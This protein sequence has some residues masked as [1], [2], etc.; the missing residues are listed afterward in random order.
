M[1]GNPLLAVITM[2]SLYFISHS[3]SKYDFTLL[4]S[5]HFKNIIAAVLGPFLQ[6]VIFLNDKKNRF[7]INTG[8]CDSVASELISHL[9]IAIRRW[10]HLQKENF[11]FSV[12][13]IKDLKCMNV[14][15]N[16]LPNILLE[17]V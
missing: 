5:C 8:F 16:V 2:N 3:F 4:Y 6:L 11:H 17:E 7:F 14:F 10:C 12:A 13:E 15:Y 9:E 1:D